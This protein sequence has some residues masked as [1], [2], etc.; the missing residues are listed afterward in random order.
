[1]RRAAILA[2]LALLLLSQPAL[3]AMPNE[4]SQKE[5]NSGK[6]DFPMGPAWYTPTEALGRVRVSV[7]GGQL[8]VTTPEGSALPGNTIDNI[9]CVC[10]PKS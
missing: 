1:M 3:G 4:P 7:E 10:S 8:I 5:S 6:L 9:L 2:S